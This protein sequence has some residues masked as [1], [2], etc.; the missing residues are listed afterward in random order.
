[1]IPLL[2][3]FEPYG[4]EARVGLFLL[5]TF[6]LLAGSWLLVRR[7]RDHELILIGLVVAAA[8]MGY[9]LMSSTEIGTAS[10]AVS[11]PT[12]GAP[13]VGVAASSS[14]GSGSLAGTLMRIAVVLV[15]AGAA[16]SL[17]AWPGEVVSDAPR[18]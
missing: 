1:M 4:N 3:V 7:I 5:A 17:L 12:A 15:L 9:G 10:V 16:R 8:A 11:P 13:N 2:A 6:I 18:P 14:L